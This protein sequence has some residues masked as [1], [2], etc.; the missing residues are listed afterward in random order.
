[1]KGDGMRRIAFVIALVCLCTS[2][3]LALT[4]DTGLELAKD[5]PIPV[6]IESVNQ[7]TQQLGLT[8][9]FIRSWV[10]RHLRQ[11]GLKPVPHTIFDDCFLYIRFNVYGPVFTWDVAF[12]RIVTYKVTGVEYSTFAS[13]YRKGG[14]GMLG[15]DKSPDF[16]I[17]E[18]LSEVTVL[19]S[20]ILKALKD[21]SSTQP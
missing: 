20:E 18:V 8:E 12:K 1:M 19:S 17:K 11:K 4:L 10:E 2:P 6:V 9:E 3:V 21:S 15:S 13:T 14:H 7:E 16:L 5:S